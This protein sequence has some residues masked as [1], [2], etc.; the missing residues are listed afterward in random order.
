MSEELPKE[1]PISEK[2]SSKS[3]I[4]PLKGPYDGKDISGGRLSSGMGAIVKDNSLLLG[5]ILPSSR[6]AVSLE[7]LQ[8]HGLQSEE[9]VFSEALKAIRRSD[10][11]FYD[12]IRD[13]ATA[14]NINPEDPEFIKGVVKTYYPLRFAAESATSGVSKPFVLGRLFKG[15]Q[16]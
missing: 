5:S 9:E 15:E 13:L 7:K 1:L 12:G 3:K 2:T 8:Q 4:F 6:A 10:H 16:Q 11:H 14:Q